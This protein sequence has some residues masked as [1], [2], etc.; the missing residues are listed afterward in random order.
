MFSKKMRRLIPLALASALCVAPLSS[1][2][3]A[4]A[5][6]GGAA[7]RVASQ[8]VPSVLTGFWNRLVSAWGKAGPSIDPSGG[9]G[10]TGTGTGSNTGSTGSG[11]TAPDGPTDP[12]G[13]G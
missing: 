6:K 10:G 8:T 9:G 12:N 2:H 5:G 13:N 3:A 11:A 7:K 4:P 1:A